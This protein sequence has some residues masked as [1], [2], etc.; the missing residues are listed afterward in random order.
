MEAEAR[1]TYVGAAVLL[2]VAALVASLLWLSNAGGRVR[3][4][5][6]V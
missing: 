5:S 2:L 4:E 3:S 6:V 1:Y